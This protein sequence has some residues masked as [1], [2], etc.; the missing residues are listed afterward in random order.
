MMSDQQAVVYLDEISSC[1]NQ[2]CDCFHTLLNANPENKSQ[3]VEI[4]NKLLSTP[5]PEKCQLW[6]S[7]KTEGSPSS[8]SDSTTS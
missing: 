2:P 6:L 4:L 5:A 1:Q 7:R 8:S 3:C